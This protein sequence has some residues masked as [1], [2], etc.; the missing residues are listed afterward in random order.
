VSWYPEFSFGV[1]WKQFS[2]NTRHGAVFQAI[3]NWHEGEAP[4]KELHEYLGWT[5]KEYKEYVEKDSLPPI[6]PGAV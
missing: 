1:R 3:E 2:A 6:R 5:L 4:D